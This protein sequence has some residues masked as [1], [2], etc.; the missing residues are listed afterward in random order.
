LLRVVIVRGGV[1]VVPRFLSGGFP[2]AGARFLTSLA[3]LG[4]HGCTASRLC[5]RAPGTLQL[6][7]AL[8]S[9]VRT[10]RPRTAAASCGE[11]RDDPSGPATNSQKS[12][13]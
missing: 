4:E 8:A 9:E 2:A 11:P 5:L 1:A 10:R 12:V 3:E 6:L 13:P 7:L